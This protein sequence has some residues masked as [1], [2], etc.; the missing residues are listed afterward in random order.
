MS[1][2]DTKEM[3]LRDFWRT[4]TRRSWVV[5]VALVATVAPAVAL[6]LLQAPIYEASARMLLQTSS[7]DSLFSTSTQSNTNANLVNNEIQVVEG[8]VVYQRVKKDLGI[9]EDPPRASAASFGDTDVVI[10]TVS[11][12]DPVTAAALANAYV[13]A[14]INTK[15]SQA[16]ASLVA[17][18]DELQ[19]KIS[20][21]QTQIDGLDQQINASSTDD[22][23]T[24]EA[25][26]RVLV[27]QQAQF[28]QRI[29][30]SQVDAALSSGG[31]QLVRP[32]EEPTDPSEPDP[33]KTALLAI[34]VGLIIGVGAAFVLDYVDDSVRDAGELTRIG[35]GLPILALVPATNA[36]DKRPIALSRPNDVTVEGYRTLRTNLQFMGVEKLMQ[37]FEVT[38]SLPGEGKTTTAANLAVV[39]SQAGSSV[40]LVDADLRKPRVH[41]MFNIEEREG[42]TDALIG[43]DF[44][45]IVRKIDDNLCVI[46]AG[47]MQPNPSEM[48]GAQRMRG[49]IEEL[50]LRFDYVIIDSAPVVAVNDSVALARHV[51]AVILVTQLGRT[52]SPQ[53]AEAVRLL[54][55]VSAPLIGFVVNRAR[56]SDVAGG[57][58]Y[59]Y[60]YEYT[61]SR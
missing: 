53:V 58:G 20:E 5:A 49:V 8:E 42:L 61:T 23:T 6:S 54:E 34:A 3:N 30:Q 60:G 57:T 15:R 50:K 52:K 24:L 2:Y 41:Q 47:A 21:L 29:D 13:D 16:V 51:D 27:D 31:A 37:V 59:G 9:T 46:T 35:N 11:S 39:L 10:V 4:I 32:A 40:V 7:N 33:I 14:Y 45:L 19:T 28:N 25:Q 44:G 38:S 18:S 55:Q 43:S 12:G 56:A 36:P 1:T 17:A 26:R 48:L 22:D